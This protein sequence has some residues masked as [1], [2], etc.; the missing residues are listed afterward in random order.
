MDD[1]ITTIYCLC[2]D[3]LKATG[4]RDNPQVRLSTTEVM[5]VAL[6]AAVFFGANIVEASRSF[7][8]EYGYTYQKRSP[9]A[10]TTEGCTL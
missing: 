8:D 3:F 7:L 5:S 2:D 6:L 9:K 1:T 10:A 4:Y